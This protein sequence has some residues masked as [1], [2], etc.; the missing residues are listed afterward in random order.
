MKILSEVHGAR[1]FLRLIRLNFS[2]NCLLRC[3]FAHGEGILVSVLPLIISRAPLRRIDKYV[4]SPKKNLLNLVFAMPVVSFQFANPDWL[5]YKIWRYDKAV[6]G[7]H[8]QYLPISNG[9][10]HR[11]GI[12]GRVRAFSTIEV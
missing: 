1:I 6:D 12:G 8:G 10:S 3:Q 7:V 9:P 4:V 2:F 11:S 5:R